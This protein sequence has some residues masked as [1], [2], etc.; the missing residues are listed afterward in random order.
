MKRQEEAAQGDDGLPAKKREAAYG[1][2]KYEKLRLLA[3]NLNATYEW[4]RTRAEGIV[5]LNL[6]RFLR[7]SGNKIWQ[8]CWH[9]HQLVVIIMKMQLHGEPHALCCQVLRTKYIT[10]Q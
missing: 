4:A 9:A 6:G 7:R 8:G 1:Y 2:S 3:Y 10:L 5:P